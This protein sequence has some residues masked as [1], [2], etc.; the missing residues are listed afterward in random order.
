MAVTC[1]LAP[2]AYSSTFVMAKVC[3]LVFVALVTL[4]ALTARAAEVPLANS[5]PIQRIVLMTATPSS[6]PRIPFI[7]DGAAH[8]AYELYLSNF[9]KTAARVVA[10]R[11]H[12]S[13]GTAF[14]SKVEGD[15]LKASFIVISSKD[16][17]KPHDPVLAPGEE[18]ILFVFLNFGSRE[19]PAEIV[20]SLVV[21]PDGSPAD[22]QVIPLAPLPIE[23]PAM[24]PNIAAPF[25]GDRWQAAN[26]PS[27][28]STHRRSVIVLDGHA[29]SPERYAI[30][31]I[32]LGEDGN[33][34][35]GDE[36]QNSSYHAY[37][38]PVTAVADGRAVVVVD[39]IPENVPH[40]E[41][42]AIELSLANIAGNNIVEDI[43]GGRY[44]GY[45]HFRPGTITVK[46]GDPIKRGQVIGKL[47]NSGNSSEPHLHIQICD[48]PSFLMC[49]GIPMQYRDMM[50]SKY[51]IEKQGEKPIHLT[52]D[53][54]PQ[55][56]TD[57][58]P[59]E[60]ELVSFPGK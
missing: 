21:A 50:M 6:G 55:A 57:Q 8:L 7:G 3:N 11:V 60:D 23:K 40:R 13:G 59:M 52:I 16:H 27:N 19:T 17:M 49:D 56:V 45:A 30:D 2:R 54:A 25:S 46:T 42:L 39:G 34:F 22:A 5:L 1:A 10:L 26:G 53:G 18:G 43:G 47:G 12:G 48:G 37:D 38:T 33:T 31:W 15:A 44:V 36:F 4:G 24:A 58:E 9:G 20:N 32:K 29:R 51:R 28:I 35:T 41:K 14:D